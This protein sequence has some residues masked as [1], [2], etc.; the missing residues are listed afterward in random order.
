MNETSFVQWPIAEPSTSIS[1]PMITRMTIEWTFWLSCDVPFALWYPTKLEVRYISILL[2]HR[3]AH[4]I[5]LL[6]T[7]FVL[8]L[9]DTFWHARDVVTH[10]WPDEDG[11]HHTNRAL[12]ISL[13]HQRSKL[14]SR[15][16]KSLVK[17]FWWTCELSLWS[18]SYI[19]RLSNPKF[20]RT[21]RSDCDTLMVQGTETHINT[22]CYNNW[23][24][25]ILS[26]SIT[27]K[28]GSIQYIWSFF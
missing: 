5:G 9:V 18:P 3:H 25:T 21:A 26:Q 11:C 16:I 15:A 20:H 24:Q 12:R 19:R 7:G 8:F 17:L 22:P 14:H 27:N 13:H 6:V 28:F 1:I 23:F 4:Y 2:S 10:V